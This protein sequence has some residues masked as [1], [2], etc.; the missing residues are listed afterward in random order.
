[1]VVF[2]VF[3][4]IVI[5]RSAVVSRHHQLKHRQEKPH[6]RSVL[7]SMFQNIDDLDEITGNIEQPVMEEETQKNDA[8]DDHKLEELTGIDID[9]PLQDHE[10]EKSLQPQEVIQNLSKTFGHKYLECEAMVSITEVTVLLSLK[11]AL[12]DTVVKVL[13]LSFQGS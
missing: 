12:L 3:L 11:S 8:T 6:F 10:I 5:F 2:Q 7:P 13:K 4:L 1:M 9:K